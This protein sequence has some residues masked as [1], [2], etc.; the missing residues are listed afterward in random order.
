MAALDVRVRIDRGRVGWVSRPVGVPDARPNDK[1]GRWWKRRRVA[2]VV[3]M[4]M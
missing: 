2:D 4:G 3:E 1:V